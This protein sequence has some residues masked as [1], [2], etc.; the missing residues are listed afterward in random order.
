MFTHFHDLKMRILSSNFLRL[1]LGHFRHKSFTVMYQKP[2]YER[3]TIK[4]NKAHVRSVPVTN[5]NEHI[6]K[7][8]QLKNE[9]DNNSKTSEIVNGSPDYRENEM[10]IQ[11]LSK[12]LHEQIFSSIKSNNIDNKQ[13]K[14]FDFLHKVRYSNALLDF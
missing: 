5:N 12:H 4:V 8:I 13:I 9:A 1:P 14:R 6:S 3:K 11:M 2:K 10:K 7:G